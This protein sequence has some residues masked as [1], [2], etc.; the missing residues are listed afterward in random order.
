MDKDF[1][2][3]HEFVEIMKVS[4]YQVPW[5]KLGRKWHNSPLQL[6]AVKQETHP[7]AGECPRWD[8]GV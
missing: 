4:I 8:S 2:K 5:W 1:D 7:P 3:L 6:P